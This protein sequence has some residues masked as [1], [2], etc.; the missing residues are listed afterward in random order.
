M[1]GAKQGVDANLDTEDRVPQHVGDASEAEQ[2]D[3]EETD[4]V[5]RRHGVGGEASEGARPGLEAKGLVDD[6]A[7]S[8]QKPGI[9]DCMPGREEGL[10]ACEVAMGPAIDE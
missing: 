10:E 9:E 7:G 8:R 5:A 4:Q 1:G 2:Q 6:P 3:A